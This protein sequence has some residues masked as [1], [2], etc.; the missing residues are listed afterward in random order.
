MAAK[1]TD[2]PIQN[3]VTL[4]D[5]GVIGR[6][7]STMAIIIYS[8]YNRGDSNLLQT[9]PLFVAFTAF[10]SIFPFNFS[11]LSTHETLKQILN[12]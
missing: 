11:G 2:G 10:V 9:F 3:N 1:V 7:T 4:S 6:T 12:H 8:D 5:R